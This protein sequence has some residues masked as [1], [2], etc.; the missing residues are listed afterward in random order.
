MEEKLLDHLAKVKA[1]RKEKRLLSQQNNLQKIADLG[2]PFLEKNRGY[3]LILNIN[4]KLVDFWPS[5]GKWSIRPGKKGNP[6]VR[7]VGLE[8]LTKSITD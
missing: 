1:K 7:G 3:H 5:S 2:I 6:P 4:D 8:N